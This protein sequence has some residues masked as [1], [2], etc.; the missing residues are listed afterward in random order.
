[1]S[2]R[3]A[4]GDKLVSSGGAKAAA[5]AGTQGSGGNRSRMR[6][7]GQRAKTSAARFPSDQQILAALKPV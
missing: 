2:F 3:E 7:F 4:K 1:M 6:H 5:Q